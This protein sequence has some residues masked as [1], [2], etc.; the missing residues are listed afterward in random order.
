MEYA[1]IIF[2]DMAQEFNIDIKWASNLMLS[3][4]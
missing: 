2:A 3:K 4:K 1:N